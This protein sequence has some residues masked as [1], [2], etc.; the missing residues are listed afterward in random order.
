L[1]RC[2]RESSHETTGI[3]FAD[4]LVVSHDLVAN[5]IAKQNMTPDMPGRARK[6]ASGDRL[7]AAHRSA[8]VP[9][10]L[11]WPKTG[12]SFATR[13]DWMDHD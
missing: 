5:G 4:Y 7:L 9:R 13:P 3:R 12:R 6:L 1:R 8:T 11:A 2:I 10:K